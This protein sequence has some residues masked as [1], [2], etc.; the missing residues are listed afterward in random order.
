MYVGVLR[1]KRSALPWVQMTRA[2]GLGG[3]EDQM[4]ELN[5]R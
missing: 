2:L 3:N 5:V 1:S 4:D